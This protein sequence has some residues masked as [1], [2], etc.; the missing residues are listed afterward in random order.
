MRARAGGL[1]NVPLPEPYLLAVAGVVWLDH[2]RP[3]PLPGARWV[4][5][6]AGWP[7][8]VAGVRLIWRSWA[9]A[10]E[11]ELDRPAHLV[12]SGPYAASRNPMYL[13][14]ALLQLGAGVV[15]GSGWTIVA[16]PAALLVHREVRREERAL[17]DAFGAEFRRY[18]ATAP[19][20]LPHR[21]ADRGSTARHGGSGLPCSCD[22][23]V[24]HRWAGRTRWM[25]PGPP[26]R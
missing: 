17:D 14:W 3:W 4:H 15:R 18:C 24:L 20:Y 21:L 2:T 16:V 26:H 9:E 12:T 22:A 13:G 25:R 5:H 10:S 6:L 19:R 1:G 23:L 11:V 7:P 8:V